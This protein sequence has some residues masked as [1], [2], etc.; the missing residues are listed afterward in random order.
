MFTN[1]CI[2]YDMTDFYFLQVMNKSERMR[3]QQGG[4]KEMQKLMNK[5]SKLK[6]PVTEEKKKMADAQKEKLLEFDRN[7]VKR[8]QVIDDQADYFSAENPWLSEE[9]KQ[10]N[11]QKRQE[12]LDAKNKMKRKVNITIDF[13]GTVMIWIMHYFYYVGYDMVNYWVQNM[14]SYI[15]RK[16]N[17]WGSA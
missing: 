1:V 16:K 14:C 9:E 6:N 8:T 10:A 7:S 5:Y 12:Y 2:W 17:N 15:Y 3:Y 11:K 4:Q 13:A